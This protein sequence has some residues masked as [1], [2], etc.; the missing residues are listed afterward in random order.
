MHVDSIDMEVNCIWEQ[1]YYASV[2]VT[3]VDATGSPVKGA[4]VSCHWEDATNSYDY[5]VTYRNG[6][7]PVLYSDVS[8][9]ASS[10]TTFT[11]VVD[12]VAKDGWTYDPD[13]NE[14]TRDSVTVP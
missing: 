9:H 7:T 13:A 10:G 3:I 12:D 4:A 2:I 6:Q 5:G 1:F 14:E 8:W 11:F